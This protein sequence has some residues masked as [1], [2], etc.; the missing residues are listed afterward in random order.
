MNLQHGVEQC[1]FVLQGEKYDVKVIVETE[2]FTT[3][4]VEY[5]NKQDY[6]TF[7]RLCFPKNVAR[8]EVVANRLD[9]QGLYRLQDYFRKR[10]SY[11][12]A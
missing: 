12:Q 7:Y 3:I 5:D 9:A 11:H 1:P 4:P 6:K 10:N 2:D 8:V